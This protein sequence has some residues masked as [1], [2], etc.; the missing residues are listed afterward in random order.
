MLT[1]AVSRGMVESSLMNTSH[2]HRMNISR[3]I[4]ILSSAGRPA[5]GIII[6]RETRP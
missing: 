4:S 6:I 5:I 3:E 1:V 2:A